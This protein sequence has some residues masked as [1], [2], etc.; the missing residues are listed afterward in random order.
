MPG[1]FDPDD[2]V[3]KYGKEKLEELI[4]HAQPLSDYYIDNVLGGGKTFEDKRDMVKTAMEFID[5]I[6]DKIEKNLFIKRI[7]EKIRH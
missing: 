5:K 4:A 7:A 3:K 1:G 6:N 2:Y